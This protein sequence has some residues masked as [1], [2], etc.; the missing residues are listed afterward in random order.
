VLDHVVGT[1]GIGWAGDFLQE[2]ARNFE[3]GEKGIYRT[4]A[5]QEII[6]QLRYAIF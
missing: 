5:A 3:D 1:N 2:I 4:A 6:S